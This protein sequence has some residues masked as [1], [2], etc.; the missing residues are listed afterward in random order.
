[1]RR[2]ITH[3]N[4]DEIFKQRERENL[5]PYMYRKLGGAAV[6]VDPRKVHGDLPATGALCKSIGLNKDKHVRHKRIGGQYSLLIMAH[7]IKDDTVL[8][9]CRFQTSAE[10]WR[11]LPLLFFPSRQLK[12]MD[13]NELAKAGVK[14]RPMHRRDDELDPV[15][16]QFFSS[17]FGGNDG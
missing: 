11:T 3:R 17:L 10:K 6:Y 14:P 5:P 9:G 8:L 2:I 12:H 1:M 15:E 16:Y 4:R 7:Y 13:G